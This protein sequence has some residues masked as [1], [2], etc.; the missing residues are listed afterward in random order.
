MAKEIKTDNRLDIFAAARPLE[1]KKAE[2]PVLRL[3]VAPRRRNPRRRSPRAAAAI[4]VPTPPTVSLRPPT[5]FLPT[6]APTPP[7]LRPP[8][9][10]PSKLRPTRTTWARPFPPRLLPRSL[11]PLP[12]RPETMARRR[13]GRRL[14]MRMLTK[15]SSMTLPILALILSGD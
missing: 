3:Q 13:A 1:A 4:L 8:R 6:P 5:S 9:P 7:L 15:L 11:L 10:V 12:A 14:M 2:F